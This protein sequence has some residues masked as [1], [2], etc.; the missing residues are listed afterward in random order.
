MTAY[1]GISEL[2]SIKILSWFFGVTIFIVT[3]LIS[4]S[5]IPNYSLSLTPKGFENFITLFN[6]PI[7]LAAAYAAIVGLISLNHRSIQTKEQLDRASTQIAQIQAQNLF[8]NYYKHREEFV[9]YSDK[10][11]GALECQPIDVAGLVHINLFPNAK[12]G[13]YA[14]YEITNTDFF[15]RLAKIINECQTCIDEGKYNRVKSSSFQFPLSKAFNDLEILT[16]TRRSKNWN[17]DNTISPYN[18][19]N[20]VHSMA[21]IFF[22]LLSDYWVMA[23]FE[24]DIQ[25]AE[26]RKVMWALGDFKDNFKCNVEL[27]INTQIKPYLENITRAISNL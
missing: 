18:F 20:S 3:I 17:F 26:T 14:P 6:A 1:K 12:G 25:T 8:A 27:E 9:K 24:K 15:E 4:T 19:A 13:D 11:A 2:T 5:V 22:L 10:I 23:R 21:S 16:G 7:K